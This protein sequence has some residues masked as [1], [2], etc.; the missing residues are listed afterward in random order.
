MY[1]DP[2]RLLLAVQSA[3]HKVFTGTDYDMN[4]IGVRSPS[5]TANAFDDAIHLV[6]WDG[7]D[8]VQ[9]KRYRATT[10]PGTYWL[11]HPMRVEGTAILCAGQYRGVYKVDK[12]RGK[13]DAL[14]QRG[15]R[16]RVY[17]DSN[18]DEVL[19]HDEDSAVEGYFGINIHRSSTRDGGSSQV[20]RW[21][22][23][24]QVFADPDDF[25]DFMA[26]VQLQIKHHPRWTSFTYTLIEED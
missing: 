4:I 11:D 14:C 6:Y 10:D 13:Y 25:A 20:D 1:D 17:R 21:S 5:R 8:Q 16:V 15:G 18:R 2:T 3:G 26:T 22:A 12:H 24:C 9:H 19:D 7:K 23:G